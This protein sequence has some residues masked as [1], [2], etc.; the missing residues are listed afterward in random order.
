MPLPLEDLA[1]NWVKY[2]LKGF[3]GFSGHLVNH[4]AARPLDE[5]DRRMVE[6]IIRRL[7]QALAAHP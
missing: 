1:D 6:H 4:A 3:E 2:L 5:R 7:E